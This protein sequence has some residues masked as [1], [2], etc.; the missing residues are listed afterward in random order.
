MPV[1]GTIIYNITAT[2]FVAWAIAMTAFAYNHF[3]IWLFEKYWNFASEEQFY[4]KLKRILR[5]VNPDTIV[6]SS[7]NLWYKLNYIYNHMEYADRRKFRNA[8]YQNGM[9]NRVKQLIEHYY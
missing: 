9:K 1:L 4:E 3:K 5:D 6:F 2:Y 7:R 8:I